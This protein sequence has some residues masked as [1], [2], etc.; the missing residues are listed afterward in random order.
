MEENT[1][2]S[3]EAHMINRYEVSSSVFNACYIS[4]RIQ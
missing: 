4:W 3:M 1:E 2:V